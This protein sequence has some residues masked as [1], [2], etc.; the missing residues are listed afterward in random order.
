MAWSH[1]MKLIAVVVSGLVVSIVLVVGCDTTS[2][3]VPAKG[4]MKL[5]FEEDAMR[6]EVLKYVTIGM[7]LEQAKQVMEANGFQCEPWWHDSETSEKHGI[8]C[9]LQRRRQFMMVTSIQ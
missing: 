3:F 6:A 7:P 2:H 1:G 4:T 9:I 8:R 5:Q